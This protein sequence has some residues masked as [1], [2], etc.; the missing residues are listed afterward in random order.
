MYPLT[1]TDS[2]ECVIFIP[3]PPIM[4]YP[5]FEGGLD[6][7]VVHWGY[8]WLKGGGIY[9]RWKPGTLSKR[10]VAFLTHIIMLNPSFVPRALPLGAMEELRTVFDSLRREASIFALSGLEAR[11]LGESF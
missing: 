5:F 8:H 2:K 3:S 9:L 10:D 6:H 7:V 1:M 11:I 4:P